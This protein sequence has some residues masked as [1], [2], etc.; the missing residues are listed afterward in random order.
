MLIACCGLAWRKSR[1]AV[2]TTIEV[3]YRQVRESAVMFCR[4][5]RGFLGMAE[6]FE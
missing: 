3:F 1:R 4:L 2:E 6:A 5:E